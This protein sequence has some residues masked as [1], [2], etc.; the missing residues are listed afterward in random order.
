M[1]EEDFNEYEVEDPNYG[2]QVVDVPFIQDKT[3]AATPDRMNHTFPENI[4]ADDASYLTEGNF[5]A[6][7]TTLPQGI[8]GVDE[9]PEAEES[10]QVEC[11]DKENYESDNTQVPDV[12]KR[13]PGWPGDNVFR[14][15][16][17]AQKVG[18]IIGRKGEFIK[19]IIEETKSRVKILDGPPG[20]MERAVSFVLF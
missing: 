19:K 5:D 2:Q 18:S 17:P 12:G 1:A 11:N 4:A 3:F 7:P 10:V 8:D 20:T 13:W 16:I 15:L 9:V 6:D 14:M